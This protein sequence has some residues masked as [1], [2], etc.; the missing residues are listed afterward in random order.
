MLLVVR[1]PTD[2]MVSSYDYE[3]DVPMVLVMDTDDF[4]VEEANADEVRNCPLKVIGL[5]DSEDGL[6]IPQ[7][8]M[9]LYS[10]D[11]DISVGIGPEVSA[12]RLPDLYQFSHILK[13]DGH[14]F[15]GFDIT[16]GDKV[17]W[18]VDTQGY[19]TFD[20]IIFEGISFEVKNDRGVYHARYGVHWVHH[21]DDWVWWFVDYIFD[22]K[23]RGMELTRVRVRDFNYVAKENGTEKRK[24]PVIGVTVNI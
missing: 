16:V 20:Q 21:R 13:P 10:R 6:Y 1:K 18:S 19:L 3:F 4:V 12:S 2:V 14:S 24:L 5:T 17:I 7:F 23:E 8:D 15:N 22:I 11:T 9:A